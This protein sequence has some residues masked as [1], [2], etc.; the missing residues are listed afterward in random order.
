MEHW[1][2]QKVVHDSQ[3]EA[4]SRGHVTSDNP[5]VRYLV[6]WRLMDAMRRLT[7]AANGRISKS[8]K[9]LLMCGG[10]GL[11]GSILCD[12]GYRNVTVSDISERGVAEAIKRDSRLQGLVLNAER[13]DVE[14]NSFE[15]VI[16]QDGLH[17]LQSPVQGFTEMLRI[18]STAVV[19]LEPHDSLIGKILGTR[20]EKH[21]D[22][23]NYVFRWTKK[24][25]QDV[26]SSYLGP[27]SFV[28]LSFSF[29]HH[30]I[31][32]HRLGKVLGDGISA[33]NIIRLIKFI[34]DTTLGRAGNQ[35]CGMILKR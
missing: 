4:G 28:N 7:T 1:E 15:V 31:V 11:E 5:L 18:A 33:L 16:V 20:W 9:I 35:F 10:E 2:R 13:A 29:W 27:D 25:A 3:F 22:A 6:R 24:L 8:S 23:V 34:L 14:S 26:A 17:H 32:Y 19:F 30:N 21:D 12:M